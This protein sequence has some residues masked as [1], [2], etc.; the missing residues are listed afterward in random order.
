MLKILFKAET[1]ND[2]ITPINVAS[3]LIE[4]ESFNVIELSEIAEYLQSYVTKC[5]RM[6][7]IDEVKRLREAGIDI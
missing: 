3:A 2:Y 7:A 4:C 5:N 6:K 1:I